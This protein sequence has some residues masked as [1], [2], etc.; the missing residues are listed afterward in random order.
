[1]GGTNSV[2]EALGVG[3]PMVVIPFV[4]DQPVNARCVEKLGVGKRL[5]YSSVNKES[6]KETVWNVFLDNDIK[7][8]ILDVRKLI[9]Q[10][11]GNQG[12]AKMIMDYY[13][14]VNFEKKHY[15]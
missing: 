9:D 10:A 8:N 12:G 2:L 4:S 5:E 14:Q 6:L 7:D 3:V 1:M 11:P 15:L 13:K